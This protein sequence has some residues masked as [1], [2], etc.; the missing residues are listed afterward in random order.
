MSKTGL[1]PEKKK[2]GQVVTINDTD[3]PI[4]FSNFDKAWALPLPSSEGKS[5]GEGIIVGHP[6][7][8]FT[9]H[10]ELL[11]GGRLKYQ[12]GK[13]FFD[14]ESNEPRDILSN[15]PVRKFPFLAFPS[16]GTK[17]ASVLMSEEGHPNKSG[18]PYPDYTVPMDKYVTGVAPLTELIPYRVTRSVHLDS[19]TFPHLARAINDCIR[20]N[21]GVISISLGSESTSALNK[22][23]REAIKNATNKGI[24]VIAA[25]AQFAG[26]NLTDPTYPG[27]DPNTI[28]VGA[29]NYDHKMLKTGFYAHEIDVTSPGV[30]IWEAR[31]DR[32]YF[33]LD[34]TP[35][36]VNVGS[37]YWTTE[38]DFVL[39]RYPP[40]SVQPPSVS[41][42]WYKEE[43][44]IE[45]S[46]GTSYATAITAGACALWQAYWGRT[47][48]LAEFPQHLIA[49]IFKLLLICSC[50][51]PSGWDDGLHGHGVLD[52][53]ALLKIN[54]NTIDRTKL[55]EIS[56]LDFNVIGKTELQRRVR[57][58]AGGNI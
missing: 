32:D 13:D 47:W 2:N 29:C 37:P 34:W 57:D 27:S 18:T 19:D 51:T 25:A 40:I 46:E 12:E 4:F 39:Y 58:D 6:D 24:V 48:L 56:E 26:D 21:A 53:E 22:S 38:R 36:S 28:C 8:G 14:P 44:D 20:V 52:A 1:T 50:D 30:D 49:R 45:Q 23:V 42:R 55:A 41:I 33:A 31:S 54:L 16:H 3:W 5:K 7:T 17:V 11:K 43:Y 9:D 15:F 35:P 10:P